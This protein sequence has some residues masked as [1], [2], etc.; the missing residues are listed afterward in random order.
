MQEHTEITLE[1]ENM[2]F[3]S[4]LPET[5]DVILNGRVEI[6]VSPS[7]VDSSSLFL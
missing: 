1:T 5:K 6:D 3:V 2:I 7:H 4:I